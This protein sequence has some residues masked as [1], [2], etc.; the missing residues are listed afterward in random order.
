MS[1]RIQDKKSYQGVNKNK[2]KL[3]KRREIGIFAFV[4]RNTNGRKGK[5][6]MTGVV[7]N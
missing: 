3:Q 1:L 2:L 6:G 4:Q 5:V 7:H